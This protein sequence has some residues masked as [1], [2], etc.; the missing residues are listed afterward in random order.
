MPAQISIEL[1]QK[2]ITDLLKRIGGI[3]DR[4][5]GSWFHTL[6]EKIRSAMIENTPY[7]TGI[8]KTSW[9]Q[10]EQCEGG[11]SF[12]NPQVYAVPLEFGSKPGER[13]WPGTG[14]KTVMH[15]GRIYSSQASGGIVQT[16][17][18]DKIIEA[19]LDKLIK[20]LTKD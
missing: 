15:G 10:I 11:L 7:D 1:D 19:C 17:N 2:S 8:A 18:L 14:P 20:D 4:S 16:A 3:S 12:S 9:G 5:P 6:T 13:P